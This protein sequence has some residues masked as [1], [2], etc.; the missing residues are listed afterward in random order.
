MGIETFISE[1][2]PESLDVIVRFCDEFD[3][4]LAIHNHGADQSPIYWRPEG[5]LEVCQ[6]RSKRIGAC[7]ETGYVV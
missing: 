1:P 6:G 5:V 7:P 3:I 2:P 4:K